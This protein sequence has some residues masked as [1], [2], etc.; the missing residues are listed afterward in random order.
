MS[1][2]L[3]AKHYQENK[4]RLQKTL[5]KLIKIILKEKKKNSN[6]IVVN[7]KKM[8]PKT[9]N[10]MS[11]IFYQSSF[12]DGKFIYFQLYLFIKVLTFVILSGFFPISS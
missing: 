1:K 4:E 7:N 6:N 3:S 8:S 11:Q 12:S 10:K 2:N 5:E 9:R